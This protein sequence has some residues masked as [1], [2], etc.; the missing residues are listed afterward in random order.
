MPAHPD[1][2]VL[3]WEASD[4]QQRERNESSRRELTWETGFM[5]Q[6]E[7]QK[8]T[9]GGGGESPKEDA[10][11]GENWVGPGSPSCCF[12]VLLSASGEGLA[13]PSMETSGQSA[14]TILVFSFPYGFETRMIATKKETAK[15]EKR[16]KESVVEV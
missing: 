1:G 3:T 5:G 11:R 9:W 4:R 8:T 14:R 6:E 13:Q 7:G 10:G 12:P 16:E 2:E 15:K